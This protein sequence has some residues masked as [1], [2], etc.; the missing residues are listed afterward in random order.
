M[1]AHNDSNRRPTPRR[2]TP[3]HATPRNA[4]QQQWS[5]AGRTYTDTQQ[6]NAADWQ[7]QDAARATADWQQQDATRYPADQR[8][9]D[10][11]Y[12][13]ADRRQTDAADRQYGDTAGRQPSARRT[14]RP[15]AQAPRQYDTY[16][17]AP[18]PKS[19]PWLPML[20][21]CVVVVGLTLLLAFG[22]PKLLSN[23]SAPAASPAPA[24]QSADAAQQAPQSASADVTA[25]ASAPASTPT[26][27][28]YGGTD[29]PRNA[30]FAVDPTRTTWNTT[31]P[32]HKTVYLTFDDGPSENTQKVL[33]I[34]DQYGIKATF[35][36]TGINTSYAPMIKECYAR[37]HTI[38]LHTYTHE[39]DQCYASSDAYWNDLNR[40]GELVREQIGYVP[41]FIRFPGG[42]SNMISADYTQGI[43]S[44]LSQ[45]VLAAGYQYYDWDASCGDGA[46]HTADELVD[47]TYWD[48][49]YVGNS[50]VFLMHD[51]A[52]KATT[53]EA[54]PRIIEYFQGLGYA[55]A[56]LDRQT[57]PPHHGIG[58]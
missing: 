35:F 50:V 39:Y 2:A 4:A 1:A 52:G 41:C 43:M 9:A 46:V 25:L 19:L 47:A 18:V 28:T 56:P 30:D 38:G 8:Y 7:Q 55:F 44:E 42:S 54:L 16:P 53:V 22:L 48:T 20:L 26:N 33:D 34:L 27:A 13:A 24:T 58:N 40:I 6:A 21:A 10:A 11:T 32:E 14:Q 45:T 57:V 3:R 23:A 5:S 37:G 17:D 49:Q 36:V 51:G 31:P 12:Y 15:P 29:D